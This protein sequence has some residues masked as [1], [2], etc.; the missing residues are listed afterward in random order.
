V[1]LKS[2]ILLLYSHWEGYIK[3]SSK[4]YLKFI[5]ENKFKLCDL[6]DNFRAVA[7]KGI[8]KEIVS[9]NETLTLQ[10]E[11]NYIKQYSKI[12]NHTLDHHIKIDLEI[13]KD[14]SIVD[15][16]DNL[17]PK[18]FKNILEIIGL[19]YKIEYESREK[20]IEKYL[21][22]NRNSIGHGNKKLLLEDDFNM[23]IM[24]IKKLRDV[25]I[26]IIENFRDEV[27]EY[28]RKEYFLKQNS[29]K[30]KEFLLKQSIE[31]EASFKEIEI[32][33]Q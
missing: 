33:Y 14:K 7:L 24:S 11:L 3:K 4:T 26:S 28:S 16:Q 31:L 20:F 32:K 19:T 10:N 5:A 15:T 22:G 2:L 30:A 9:S 13:E 29:E 8:S 12:D 6:T 23:E 18:V 21:L 1:L 17:N 25:I 27:I